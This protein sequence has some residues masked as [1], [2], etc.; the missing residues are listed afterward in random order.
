MFIFHSSPSNVSHHPHPK[1]MITW[2]KQLF[3]QNCAKVKTGLA[4]GVRVQGKGIG[5][6]VEIRRTA[7][8]PLIPDGRIFRVRLAAM[9]TRFVGSMSLPW[10]ISENVIPGFFFPAVGRLGLTS[11]PFRTGKLH[12]F[13]GTTVS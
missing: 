12:L 11:P 3:T 2:Q 4:L 9:V 13:I 10:F 5:C 8:P 6:W 1:P 7:S